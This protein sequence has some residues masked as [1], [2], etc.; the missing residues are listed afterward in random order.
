MFIS[1]Q[2]AEWH[3]TKLH[4]GLMCA[5][6]YCFYLCCSPLCGPWRP[7]RA[8]YQ[9]RTR[10]PSIL[11]RRSCGVEQFAAYFQKSASDSFGFCI[12]ILLFNHQL[13]LSSVCCSDFTD[14]LWCLINYRII[15]IINQLTIRTSS[16]A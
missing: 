2:G 7:R 13:N 3:G 9:T 8:S 16:F 12:R 1:L 15:I 6:D 10:Q 11:H 14:M 5:G 4:T